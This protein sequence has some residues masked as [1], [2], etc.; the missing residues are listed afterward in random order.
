VD[1]GSSLIAP[2]C[3]FLLASV[4]VSSDGILSLLLHC[5]VLLSL[6]LSELGHPLLPVLYV[7]LL[8]TNRTIIFLHIFLELE[9]LKQYDPDLVSSSY[10]VVIASLLSMNTN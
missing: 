4:G 10:K 3:S 5:I 9:L 6:C 2:V 8:M 7:G 1:L